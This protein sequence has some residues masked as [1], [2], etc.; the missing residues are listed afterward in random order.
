M[1][2][3]LLL[4]ISVGCSLW[5]PT[6]F[7]DAAA[8]QALVDQATANLQTAYSGYYTA[9]P[10]SN[11][12]P[13]APGSNQDDNT[14]T[15]PQNNTSGNPWVKPNP[16]AAPATSSNAAPAN[17]S[18]NNSS[19]NTNTNSNTPSNIYIPSSGNNNTNNNTPS[20]PAT[21][22]SSGSVNIYK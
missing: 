5:I 7:A 9:P 12:P 4:M 6:C 19:T 1:R 21:Y 2:K 3:G 20:Y 14:K 17:N 8:A 22:P 10:P 15:K 16:W 11:P 18:A 13:N